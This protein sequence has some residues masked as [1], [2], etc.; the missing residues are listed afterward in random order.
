MQLSGKTAA[1]ATGLR[2]YAEQL[3]LGLAACF[4][5]E[6]CRCGSKASFATLSCAALHPPQSPP[7]VLVV[8]AAPSRFGSCLFCVYAEC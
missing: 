4:L 5:C 6:Y 2:D 3:A 8:V 1:R 7:V